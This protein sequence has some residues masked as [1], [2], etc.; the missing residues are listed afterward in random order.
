MS[1]FLRQL[2]G[3]GDCAEKYLAIAPSQS[4]NAG[5]TPVGKTQSI[6]GNSSV[7]YDVALPQTSGQSTGRSRHAGAQVADTNEHLWSKNLSLLTFF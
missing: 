6:A 2:R 5:F 1:C 7:H 4:M 3:F